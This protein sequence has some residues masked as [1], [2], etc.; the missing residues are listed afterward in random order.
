MRVVPAAAV[1]GA[2]AFP[3]L[4][5][6][7]ADAFR[8]DAHVP[9]R[10]HH[11]IEREV[12]ATLLLMPAWTGAAQD[13]FVGVKVVSVFPENGARGLPAV[14]GSYLL[15]DGAT[16]APLAVMDGTRLTVW[17]TAAAS[18]LA[19]RHLA[20]ADAERMVMV[21]SGALAPFLI[22]AHLSQRPIRDVALWNHRPEKAEALARSL[23]ADGLPVR[24]VGDVESAVRAADLVSCATLSTAPIV[25]GAWLKA[26]AHL[27]LVGAFNLRMREADDAAVRR[28]RVFVDTPAARHEGGDVALALKAGAI[29]EDHVQGDLFGLCR[30]TV[31]GRG[32]AE[33]ITLFKSVGTALEDLAAAMLVWRRLGA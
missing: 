8:S 33:E 23:S 5:E 4:I 6:A 30:G 2:L 3:D 14:L 16:G 21:G 1:D 18:A 27:D 25:Q 11:E 20:R 28:A 29:S 7:L 12:P 13:G 15:L 26:G 10:H 31:A 19:A 17:R 24:A 22:R 32:S 9:V